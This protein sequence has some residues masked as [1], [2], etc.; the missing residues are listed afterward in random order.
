[1]SDRDE[2]LGTALRELR[3]PEHGPGFWDALELRLAE[4]GAASRRAPRRRRLRPPR[5]ALAAA[6]AAAAV[7]VMIGLPRTDAPEPALAEVVK[8]RVAG[9]VKGLETLQGRFSYRSRTQEPG[10]GIVDER[11]RR[12]S[13]S[14]TSAGD[15]RVTR[16]GA[17]AIEDTAYSAR[18]GTQRSVFPSASMGVGRFYSERRGLPPGPPDAGPEELVIERELGSAVRALLAAKDPRIEETTYQRRAAWRVRLPVEPNLLLYAADV[19]RIDVIVDQQTGF[20]LRV[21]ETLEGELRSE[22]RIDDLEVN[23]RLP[24]SAFEIRFPRRAEVLRTDGGFRRVGL[25]EVA[26]IVGYSPLV[27]ARLPEGYALSEVAAARRPAPTGAEG[28]NPPSRGVVSLSYRRG[29]DQVIVSSRLAA[30]R[31]WSDPF[32]VEGV[33]E[34]RERLRLSSGALEGAGAE[35]VVGP[36]SIP[37]LWA[38]TDELVV[39]VSGD[40]TRA[41]LVE[42]AES[43]R[44]AG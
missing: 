21:R 2:R 28:E 33:R 22:L 18:T 40:L 3:A 1:M 13:F 15:F 39:T 38:L 44:P 7:T 6:V 37:H 24:E 14:F 11:A 20:P 5:W 29:F 32:A 30:R 9:A 19:D 27:P 23:G 26:G 35:L 31:D 25:H 34:D 43:L 10:T 36:R 12:F 17:G 41:E 42:A 4:E 8:Q 16:L